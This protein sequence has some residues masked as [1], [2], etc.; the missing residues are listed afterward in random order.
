MLSYVILYYIILYSLVFY[1]VLLCSM[2]FFLYYLI[3]YSLMLSYTFLYFAMLLSPFLSYYILCLC[4]AMLYYVILFYLILPYLTFCFHLLS[5]LLFSCVSF[6][7]SVSCCSCSHGFVHSF[8][9]YCVPYSGSTLFSSGSVCSVFIPL[10]STRSCPDILDTIFCYS[11]LLR[12]FHGALPS[13]YVRVIVTLLFVSCVSPCVPVSS[14]SRS[15]VLAS[16]FS[17]LCLIVGQ[18]P[19]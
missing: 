5:C 12:A 4:Y 14:H 2:M 13:R 19:L 17:L 15:R 10:F 9:L 3:R 1:D 11:L 18:L 16:S 7:F 8:S 6:P